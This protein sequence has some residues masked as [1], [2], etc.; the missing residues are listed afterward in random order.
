MKEG[1]LFK[2]TG[3]GMAWNP[4][5]VPSYDHYRSLFGKKDLSVGLMHELEKDRVLASW[6]R[7]CTPRKILG[8]T[9]PR[10][11]WAPHNKTV[12]DGLVLVVSILI[13]TSSSLPKYQAIGTG[14]TAPA[15]G[16]SALQT[17]KDRV[18][19]SNIFT[20]SSGK[21]MEIDAF[22][23]NTSPACGNTIAEEGIFNLITGGS[24]LQRA[25]YSPTIT[26]PANSTLTTTL[27]WTGASST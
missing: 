21:G 20:I 10:R 2:G 16:D 13:G 6:G 18:N 5:T 8:R 24:M 23:P 12:D 22:F 15:A 9:L 17:E 7:L 25:L 14:S 19:A 1:V 4:D 11:L 27:Q 26:Y 3:W